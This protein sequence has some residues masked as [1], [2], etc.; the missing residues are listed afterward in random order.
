MRRRQKDKAFISRRTRWILLGGGLILAAFL[1][2]LTA[3][4]SPGGEVALSVSF[5]GLKLNAQL[6]WQTV[7]LGGTFEVLSGETVLG[8][9]TANRTQE[10]RDAGV[11]ESLTVKTQDA[12]LGLFLRP[13]KESMPSSYVCQD[14]IPV[15][16]NGEG[17]LRA[18]VLAY[19]REGLFRLSNT[20]AR[21]GQPAQSAEFS[22]LDESGQT[23]YSF[24]T[25]NEGIYNAQMPLPEGVYTLRQTLSPEGTVPAE[26]MALAIVPYLGTEDSVTGLTVQNAPVP[27]H[28]RLRGDM[29]VETRPA[30]NLYAGDQ[31]AEFLFSSHSDE[32]NTLP[33]QNYTID[34]SQLTLLDQVGNAHPDQ[35]GKEIKS[36]IVTPGT[37]GIQARARAYDE[38]GLQIGGERHFAPGQELSLDGLKAS[39]VKIVY[40]A[41]D[42]QALVPEAFDPGSIHLKV[43]LARRT[44]D[45]SKASVAQAAVTMKA[46]WQYQYPG[47]DRNIVTAYGECNSFDLRTNVFDSRAV[48]SVTGAADAQGRVSVTVRHEGGPALDGQKLAVQLPDGWRVQDGN[49]QPPIVA[50]SRG[51]QADILALSL[52]GTLAEGQEQTVT[53][54]AS[55]GAGDGEG[56]SWVLSSAGVAP[57]LDNPLGL[58]VWGE[59]VE[60][61]PVADAA[62]GLDQPE[63]YA[64]ASW[65]AKNDSDTAVSQPFGYPGVGGEAALSG[66]LFDDANGNGQHEEGE[67][68]AAGQLVMWRGSANLSYHTYTDAQGKF[69]FSGVSADGQ[70]GELYAQLPE[71]TVIA[72]QRGTGGLYLAAQTG[73]SNQAEIQIAFSRMCAL[74]GRVYEQESHAGIAGVEA[75]LITG[76]QAAAS[77]LTD[78]Q[79]QYRFDALASGDYQVALKLPDALSSQAGFY[80]G[81]GYAQASGL[82]ALLPSITLQYGGEVMQDGPVRRY[83]SLAVSLQGYTYPLGTASLFRE[84]RLLAE[85]APADDGSYYFNRLFSGAYTLSLQV[86]QGLAIRAEG[87]QSWLKG[88]VSLDAEVPAGGEKQL[89]LEETVTGSL[90]VAFSGTGVA[91]I[92]VMISGPE[93]R[94]GVLDA[95]GRYVFSDLIPGMY[96][97]QAALPQTVLE[98]QSGAWRIEP[99]QGSMTASLFVEVL[100]GQETAPQEALLLQAATV[101]GAVF[102]DSDQDGALGTGEAALSGARVELLMEQAGTWTQI[103]SVQTGG[104]GLFHF[105]NLVP[106]QYRLS[107]TLPKGKALANRQAQEPFTLENGQN[108]QVF[109]GAVSPAALEANAFWD[110][111]NDGL[112]GIYERAIEGTLVEVLPAEGGDDTVAAKGMTDRNGQIS[113]YNLAPGNYCIRFTLPEGYWLSRQ[114]DVSG[115]KRNTVPIADSRQ[116]VTQPFTLKEGQKAG[117]GVGGIKTG[118]ISGRVWLDVNADGIMTDGE[119]GQAGCT[120][121]LSGSRNGQNY[122]YTTDDTGLY[123]ITARTD[124]YLFTVKGPDGMSF[125]RSSATGGVN[126]S[127]ITTEGTSA[128]E[129]KYVFE[130]GT[131]EENQNIGFVPGAVLHGVAFLDEN[132]NGVFDSGEQ[133]LDGVTLELTRTGSSKALKS[134]ATGS[135]GA[136]RFDS[137]WGGEYD[138]RAVLPDTGVVFTRVPDGGSEHENLFARRKGKRETTVTLSLSS[139]ERRAVG[140]GAVVPGSLSGLV[141]TDTNYNGLYDHGEPPVSSVL[142]RLLDQ[143]GETVASVE[144]S[145]AGQYTF[146]G[147]MPMAYT[148]A[149]E[150]PAGY[151]FTWQGSGESRSR[152][153]ALDKNEGLTGAISV[154]LGEQ[155]KSV[156]AG[157]ILPAGVQGKVFGDLNDD[158]LLSQGE[159]GFE[160]VKVSLMNEAGQVVQSFTTGGSGDFAFADLHPGR[161]TLSY[162]LPEGAVYAVKVK[163]GNEIAGEDLTAFGEAF[164]LKIGETKRAPL[165]GAVALGRMSGISFHDA[166][167]NG[168]RE[169]GEN[170]LSGVRFILT[171]RRTGQEAGNVTTGPDGAFLLD[172][173]R[174]GAYTLSVSLPAGMVFTRAGSNILM[175]SILG[176]QGSLDMDIRMGDKLDGRLVGGML[177]AS[178]AGHVWLDENNN[179]LEEPGEARLGGLKVQVLDILTG[180]V[181][182][183]LT[184]DENGAYHVP[185]IR[186][187]TYDLT[188]SLPENSIA[189]DTAAGEN[190]FH[191]GAPGTVTLANLM[192]MEGEEIADIRA[193]V[194]QYTS[195]RGMVWADV[196]GTISPLDGVQVS[197]YK[198]DD[199]E[200]P[201]KTVVTAED[202]AYRFDRLMPGKYR[203]GA[204]LKPG[205]LFVKPQDERLMAGE[206]LS[207]I[208][209]TTSGLGEA[210]DLVMGKNQ[211]KQDIGAVRTG[212]L[213]DFV[214]LDE[215]RNGLQDTGEPGIPGMSVVLIQD[216][217][218]VAAV[219]T[220]AYGYYLFDNVYPMP[221]QV[222]AAMYTELIPTTRRTDYPLLVSA[223]DGFEGDKAYTVDVM[224]T[225]GG[226]NFNCDLGFVLKEGSKRPD[227]I[228]PPPAQKWD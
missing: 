121:T 213:G 217:Q 2:F 173:L 69:D 12:G 163:G 37:Q 165:C 178:L 110:S 150:K 83:G 30:G 126:R 14:I 111:N 5:R 56:A 25:D 151:M 21:D 138:L 135:D 18:D 144:T 127:I 218:Q 164:D 9:V 210:F 203:I 103:Q 23:V 216:G 154:A 168:V 175:D 145:A 32:G 167:A 117:F 65:T 17:S 46:S 139:G 98:D 152:V 86:P 78:A 188:V 36:L 201:L 171:S 134:I 136:F 57:T 53:F 99:A 51:K 221:S 132:Y 122:I 129:R 181:F 124:T 162:L 7:P 179:G 120:I 42:G 146:D 50:V 90:M 85:S 192:L 172:R 102:E 109:A 73:L 118:T 191:D 198:A 114:G 35:S 189:A 101:A 20:L 58:A 45:P 79:G 116:G 214:W 182:T 169:E 29:A 28:D 62:L 27:L 206:A 187:G 140:A 130:S 194:R 93:D 11:P 84:G 108:I 211:I 44:P 94:Q 70:M 199:L 133:L 193:G 107:I 225:S 113:F 97:V 160:G 91:D 6:Q 61:C 141:F 149:V 19:A 166:N 75:T 147:L 87:T 125:T 48:V 49:I 41:A 15:A 67:Q 77:A 66:W 123:A 177:P 3:G 205:Y 157:V 142:I 219:L 112:Q 128:G 68:G 31:T 100:P 215:N 74:Y 88:P 24:A 184:T 186:P 158:G 131:R 64:Y 227:A 115:F 76:G 59:R 220:D 55:L 105:G 209:D 16:W 153:Q 212:K 82:K 34:I 95:N 170:T 174:P 155:V 39:S 26:D 159:G 1:S 183:T 156:Y 8:E 176:A 119:P 224:V 52:P 196:Q 195:I 200:K 96:Q 185:V 180:S 71:N 38:Q 92:P 190:I 223:L 10:Q 204:A 143:D 47:R 80:P 161:Y 106:G 104:D 202:G 33:L 63:M 54:S 226:K 89:A 40:V 72:G 22:V 197:L 13:V 137:L 60:G 228:K 148:L 222:Q 43:G 81:D 207:I 208:S 4:A